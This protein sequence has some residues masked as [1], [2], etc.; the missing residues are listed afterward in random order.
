VDVPELHNL[1]DCLVFPKKGER[2]HANE[3]SDSDL[4]GDVYIMTWDE[5]ILYLQ[6]RRAANLWIT[7]QPR[8]NFYSATYDNI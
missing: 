3:A 5:R 4:D 7:L 8:R 1:V 6:R 2:P